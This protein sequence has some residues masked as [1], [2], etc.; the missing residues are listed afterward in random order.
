MRLSIRCMWRT[1]QVKTMK[2]LPAN[3]RA[4]AAALATGGLELDVPAALLLSSAEQEQVH[5][6]HLPVHHVDI[7]LDLHRSA[8][9]VVNIVH[10]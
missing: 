2:A 1:L 10:F 5:H 3:H 7:A 8:P 6:T 9:P 4:V